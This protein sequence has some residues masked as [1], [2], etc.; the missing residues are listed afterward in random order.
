V[1]DSGPPTDGLRVHP[2]GEAL[3]IITFKCGTNSAHPQCTGL[4]SHHGG[5]RQDISSQRSRR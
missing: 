1:T 2:P 5:Q 4:K 3:V